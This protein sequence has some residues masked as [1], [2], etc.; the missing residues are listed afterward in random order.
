MFFSNV[1]QTSGVTDVMSHS[2]TSC[3]FKLDTKAIVLYTGSG[4]TAS[5]MTRFKPN[6]PIVAITDNP[7]TYH[8]LSVEWNTL[9]IYTKIE[10]V[11]IFDLA[12]TVAKSI[13]LAK[14]GDN[15]IVTT[16]TTDTLNNVMKVCQID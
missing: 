6:A 7:Q 13:K 3:S 14:T 2:A 4:K 9:P 1:F 15:I 8:A 10:N 12:I 11:D 16:G 5:M